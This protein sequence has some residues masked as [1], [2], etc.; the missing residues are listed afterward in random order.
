MQGTMV[1][2]VQNMQKHKEFFD[3]IVKKLTFWHLDFYSFQV[4]NVY[5]EVESVCMGL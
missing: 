2:I 5:I 3:C 4:T 1:L